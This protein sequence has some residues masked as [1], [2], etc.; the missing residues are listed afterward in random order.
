MICNHF[1]SV[2]WGM[3]NIWQRDGSP[4]RPWHDL[5]LHPKHTQLL[6]WILEPRASSIMLFISGVVGARMMTQV[7]ILGVHHSMSVLWD[8]NYVWQGWATLETMAWP[9]TAPQTCSVATLDIGTRI[10][11]HA[12]RQWCLRCKD[13]GTYM[14]MIQ[15]RSM[16][17]IWVMDH[18]W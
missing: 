18:F 17:V 11:N 5:Q 13:D 3:D 6:P 16:S 15:N 12:P 2:I 7:C 4:H 9:P 14:D 1:M 10:L 8:I